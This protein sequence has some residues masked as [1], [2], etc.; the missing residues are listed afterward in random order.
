MSFA[1]SIVV[2]IFCIALVF[3]VLM[4]FIFPDCAYFPK[5]CG[6]GRKGGFSSELRYKL[7]RQ[8]CNLEAVPQKYGQDPDLS[9]GTLKLKEAWMKKQ[10]P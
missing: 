6:S 9:V 2:S 3:F 7:H 10:Q 5:Y 1:D 4:Q 8:Q